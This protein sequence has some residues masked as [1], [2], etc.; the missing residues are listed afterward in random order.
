LT[1]SPSF[2]IIHK[3]TKDFPIRRY[4][5]NQQIRAT[6]VRAI[7]EDGKNLGE[8]DLE[9]AFKI[10]EEN[11]IDVIEIAPNANP[12]VVRIMD[13]GKFKYSEAKK[14]REHHPKEHTSEVKLLRIGVKTA[15]H[16]QERMATQAAEFLAEGHK[17]RIDMVLRGREKALKDFARERFNAFIALIPGATID[18]P[19]GPG[20]RGFTVMLRKAS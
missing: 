2:S 18:Q 4:R 14:E 5:I 13:F 19:V 3:Q 7:S 6:R 10:A 17:V 20:P 11:K 16:D 12:P 9:Q 15:R 1:K 8:M